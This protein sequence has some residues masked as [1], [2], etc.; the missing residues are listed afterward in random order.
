[1]DFLNILR[2]N[3]NKTN[4]IM[5]KLTLSKKLNIYRKSKQDILRKRANFICTALYGNMIETAFEPD[6]YGLTYIINRYFPEL[7]EY[8]K[9]HNLTN[10]E[11]GYGWFGDVDKEENRL[12]RIEVIDEMILKLEK[13][14]RI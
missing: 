10:G 8:K 1:M 11:D 6:C 14:G 9:E 12:K 4:N 3:N 2:V 5:K 7:W 13:N